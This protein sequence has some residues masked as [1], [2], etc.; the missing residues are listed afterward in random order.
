MEDWSDCLD[1]DELRIR[2]DVAL[3]ENAELHEEIARLR[4][5]NIRLCSL[6]GRD[7]QT[8]PAGMPPVP[9]PVTVPPPTGT[10]GLP[11]ADASSSAEAK[12]ALFKALFAGRED[13]YAKRWTSAKSGRTGWS[14]AEDNPFD[15]N[16]AEEGRVFWPL[17][18]ET[19]YRHL[20]ATR[21][22]RSELHIGLYPLLADD[23]C[24]LLACDFDGKDDSDWRAD[25]TAYI[26]ACHEA[27]VPALLEISRSGKGAHAWTFFTDPVAAATA[28]ALGMA[29]LRR[30]ID[31]RGQ[32]A[33]SSYDRLFPAQD[34]LPTKAKGSFRFGNLIALPLHGACR[35][36]RTTIFVDPDT[37]QPFPDQFAHLSHTQR[38]SP[39]SVE[40]LVDKLG[41]VTAA[42]P[43]PPRSWGPS[44]AARPSARRPRAFR[45][46]SR[47]C[48]RSPRP[49]SRRNCWPHSNT[50]RRSTTRSSTASRTSAS[51]PSTP[52][53]SSAA[54]TPPIQTGSSCPVA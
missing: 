35:A 28:R 20:D 16:K 34:F 46:G 11:Y 23:T 5:D 19:I 25:A 42:H 53:T 51:P 15:K 40:A 10:V 17:T 4:A 39:A 29:L 1:P 44:P 3:E 8:V 50:R 12:I 14:P 13:V 48:W 31:A 33:L 52:R 24:R 26:A 27:G 38:L 18:D 36:K 45:P 6:L 2:L 54:S 7:I 49:G 22:G 32:M 47:R 43:R 9:E 21:S 41:P 30:A 37:W